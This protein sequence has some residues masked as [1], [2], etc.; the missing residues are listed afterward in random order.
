MFVESHTLFSNH[1]NVN[2]DNTGERKEKKESINAAQAKTNP[3]DKETIK[4]VDYTQPENYTVDFFCSHR[5]SKKKTS[6]GFELKTRWKGFT[7]GE[8]TWE[9]ITNQAEDNPALVKK[10][11]IK[12]SAKEAEPIKSA[13]KDLSV[14]FPK[15][16]VEILLHT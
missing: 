3:S 2:T 9:P 1:C 4:E 13:L 14:F 7:E 15:G 8:D 11:L 12:I 5:V 16:V 10:Y 6:G